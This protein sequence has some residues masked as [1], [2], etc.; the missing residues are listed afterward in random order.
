MLEEAKRSTIY[1][2]TLKTYTR[3]K[4]GRDAYK[5]M[6]RSHIGTDKWDQ[7]Q[8]DNLKYVMNTKWNGK[9]YALDKFTGRHRSRFVQL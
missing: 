8:K 1:A 6:T 7:L 4:N 2:P 3:N 9:N 5:A